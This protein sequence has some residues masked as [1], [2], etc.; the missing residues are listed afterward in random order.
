VSQDLR[1]AYLDLIGELWALSPKVY[2][3]GGYA[4]DALLWGKTMR[5]H[6]DIDVLVRRVQLDERMR[7]FAALGFE[8][9]DVYYEPRPGMP[10]VL[11]G[12]KGGLHLEVSIVD[13]DGE[14][15]YFYLEAGDRRYRMY[16]EPLTFDYAP[17]KIEGVHMQTISPLMLY[18]IRG[19]L[20]DTGAF[21]EFRPHDAER[22]RLLKEKFF[23]NAGDAE[24]RCEIVEER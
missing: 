17:T 22:Q 18:Q 3:F 21:G 12:E 14:R 15:D 20:A 19:G 16:L 5:D 4:E 10:Q 13:R 23:P 11:N 24:L 2:V 1:A 7:Q 9:F 6:S 8:R